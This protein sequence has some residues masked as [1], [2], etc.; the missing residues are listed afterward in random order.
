MNNTVPLVSVKDPFNSAH[1]LN[2]EVNQMKGSLTMSHSG[3]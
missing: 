1:V 2:M 3:H